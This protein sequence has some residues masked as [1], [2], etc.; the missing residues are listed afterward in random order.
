MKKLILILALIMIALPLNAG[1]KVK[2]KRNPKQYILD[3]SIFL[4]THGIYL[5]Y[6]GKLYRVKALYKSKSKGYYTYKS[7]MKRI[8]L[9]DM[10]QYDWM[11]LTK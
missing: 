10:N 11:Q 7:K 2:S 8:P 9:E 6:P 4:Y 5:A 1:P 3:D